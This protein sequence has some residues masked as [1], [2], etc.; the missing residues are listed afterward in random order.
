MTSILSRGDGLIGLK[1]VLS[2]NY[3]NSITYFLSRPI[4][5]F[6]TGNDSHTVVLFAKFPKDSSVTIKGIYEPICVG[7]A[8]LAVWH[9]IKQ[10]LHPSHC[11]AVHNLHNKTRS[12]G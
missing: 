10:I 8:S 12:V 3:I 1:S 4:L 7:L 5:K 2:P 11:N 6:R 9:V